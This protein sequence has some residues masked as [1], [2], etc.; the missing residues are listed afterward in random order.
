VNPAL[1]YLLRRSLRNA[2]VGRF[3]RLRNP[4]YLLLFAVGAAYFGLVFGPW[5][6]TRDPSDDWSEFAE[7][8]GALFGMLMA[9]GAWLLPARKSPLAFLEA[10]VALLFPAPLSRRELVSYKLLDI[11]KYLVLSGLFFALMALFRSGPFRAATVLC[12]TWLGFSVL[13][14]HQ[15]GAHLTRKSLLD[16]GVSGWRRMGIPLM[17]L[18]ALVSVVAMGT[19]PLPALEKE[20]FGSRL[21]DWLAALGESPAGWA[22]LPF[23]LLAR[24]MFAQD[25]PSFLLH[26]GTLGGLGALL[27]LWV[28]RTDAAFEEA[29]AD[30]AADL[31]RRIDAARRGKF[32]GREKG[33][34][35]PRRN[36]WRLGSAGPPE[37]AFLWKSVAESLRAVSPRL[38]GILIAAGALGIALG[39]KATPA[40]TGAILRTVLAAVMLAGAGLLVFGGPSFLGSNLRQDMEQVELL[41]TLP[42]AP[43]RLVRCSLAGAVFPTAVLQ[44]LLVGG[45]AILL[46]APEK[47]GITLA[48]RIAGAAGLAFVLPALAALSATADAAGVLFF[49]AWV[50]PGQAPA[51]GVEAM[52]YGIILM[53]GK[54]ALLV[55]GMA[56]PAAAGGAVVLLA[57]IGGPAFLPAGA[58]MGAVAAAGAALAEVALLSEVL[59]RRFAV[60]DPAEESILS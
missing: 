20:E 59:G 1:L 10:E 18:A 37:T 49:P 25:L 34:K 30:Q 35:P 47:A 57:G 46:P 41:K 2:V 28:I 24:P 21:R 54:F 55:F 39:M 33:R 5:G 52:G 12:G 11:Q 15:V 36:P 44:A 9:A 16:H 26:A 38:I 60:L 3:R 40:G 19:P 48:W 50:R 7:W 27:Y 13:T 58:W 6:R 45:A 42:V 51:Q 8:G 17:V 29:A 4:R 14:L 31:A 43:G 56:V 22:L 32:W 53:I 23:R